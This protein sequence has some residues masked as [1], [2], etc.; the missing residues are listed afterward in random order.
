MSLQKSLPK[1]A[2]KVLQ[3]THVVLS[4]MRDKF[5]L[6]EIAYGSHAVEADFEK[7]CR[8]R[9]EAG[10]RPRYPLSEYVKVV[11]QRLGPEFAEP[12]K[13][14]LPTD[15]PRIAE[16]VGVVYDETG[17]LPTTRSIAALMTMFPLEEIIAAFKEYAATLDSKDYK[18]SMKTFF[19]EGAAGVIF[20]RRRRNARQ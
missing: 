18:V 9:L 6:I 11:D 14:Q 4:R 16:F 12:S 17:Y 8:E 13:S 19:A 10:E 20:A 7:W 2:A 5:D 1:I 3:N 15:D